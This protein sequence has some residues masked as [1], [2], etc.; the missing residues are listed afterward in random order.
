MYVTVIVSDEQPAPLLVAPF[1]QAKNK[2]Q[3]YRFVGEIYS[4]QTRLS[5]GNEKSG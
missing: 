5:Y 4:R 3:K 1:G 2:Q